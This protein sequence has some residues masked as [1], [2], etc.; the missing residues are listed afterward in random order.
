MNPRVRS[1]IIG[2]LVLLLGC[3]GK[4]APTGTGLTFATLVVTTTSLPDA[5]FT[6]V[7]S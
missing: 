1:L 3:G 4:D 2:S 5:A 6:V 7:Y